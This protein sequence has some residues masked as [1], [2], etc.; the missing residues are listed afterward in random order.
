MGTHEG[1]ERLLALVAVELA[2]VPHGDVAFRTDDRRGDLSPIGIRSEQ[3]EHVH[4]GTKPQ[5]LEHLSGLPAGI[6][7]RVV[8]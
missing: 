3:I 8:R 7:F 2:R 5:I 1:F 4:T 6:Q